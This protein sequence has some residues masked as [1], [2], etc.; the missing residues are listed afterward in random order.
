MDDTFLKERFAHAFGAQL[1]NSAGDDSSLWWGAVSLKGR[2]YALPEG[3]VGTRF[4]HMLSEEIEQCN[5]GWQRSEWEFIFTALILQRNKMI[6]KGK[7][8]RPLL[9]RQMEMW[10]AG[11][12]HELLQEARRCDKQLTSGWMPMTTEQ[13]E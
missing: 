10:E 6:R 4:V 12:R 11:R 9:T 2:Q 13:V 8:I 5:E 1:L 3:G 7:D